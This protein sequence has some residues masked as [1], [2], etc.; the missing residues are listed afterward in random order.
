LGLK[1][2]ILKCTVWNITLYA[3]ETQTMTRVDRKRIEAFV[4]WVWRRMEK[5]SQIDK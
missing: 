2:K 3:A 5:I 4:M 1:K